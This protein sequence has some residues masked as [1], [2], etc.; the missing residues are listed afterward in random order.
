MHSNMKWEKNKQ[1]KQSK[2]HLKPILL[3]QHHNLV[4]GK[5]Q[6]GIRSGNKLVHK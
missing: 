6:R 5:G 4:R 2:L 1:R 3:Q